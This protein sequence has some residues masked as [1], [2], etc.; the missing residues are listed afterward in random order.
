MAR[1]ALNGR[2]ARVDALDVAT[3]RYRVSIQLADGRVAPA[4][5]KA[6]NLRPRAQAQPE[7]NAARALPEAS[8]EVCR[9]SRRGFGSPSPLYL[10]VLIFVCY[11]FLSRVA[12]STA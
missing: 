12:T 1:V 4:R 8:V 10:T 7:E 11:T 5:L 6:A 3:G 9:A 2:P